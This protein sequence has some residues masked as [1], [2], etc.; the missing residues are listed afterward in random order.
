MNKE[1]ARFNMI[2]QQIR[3]CNVNNSD[4][5]KLLRAVKREQFVPQSYQNLA[6]AD[7]EIPL[8][9]G[10][11]MLSPTVEAKMLQELAVKKS[12]C[13]LE[14]GT[15]SGFMAAMLAYCANEVLS[16]EILPELAAF[17]QNKLHEAGVT[18]ATVVVGDAAR[19][20]PAAAPYDVIMVSG[21]LPM[22]PPTLLAQLNIGGRLAAFVGQAPVMEAQIVTRVNETEYRTYNLFE[23]Y[24]EHLHNAQQP[25]PSFSCV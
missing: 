19:G 22:I 20:W 11:C 21:G 8:P 12:D 23:T 13:V 6:Y 15:G 1:K 10:Q 5:L 9:G 17:A 2:E 7:L 24:V 4:I 3:P 25:T 16:V 14:I 18:N